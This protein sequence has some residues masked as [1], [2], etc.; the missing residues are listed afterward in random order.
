MCTKIIDCACTRCSFG[1][2]AVA[3]PDFRAVSVE[4]GFEFDDAA[5]AVA[6]DQSVESEEVGV[7]SAIF[8]RCELFS[9]PRDGAG[10]L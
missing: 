3:G 2:P 7:P 8:K 6:F 5:E 10:E 1:F 4:V 9:E